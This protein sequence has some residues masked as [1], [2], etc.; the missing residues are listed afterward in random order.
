MAVKFNSVI[1]MIVILVSTAGGAKGTYYDVADN[2]TIGSCKPGKE[3][4]T[5]CYLTLV[6]SLLGNGDNMFNLMNV[7]TP[8]NSNP[9]EHVIVNY[10]FQ[11][12]RGSYTW[13]WATSF[14]YFLY[15]PAHFQF[16]S[17]FFGK[18]EHLHERTVEVT[19]PA[20]CY[21]VKKEFMLLLTQRVR[22]TVHFS[23]I[24]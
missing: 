24:C 21:G 18:P 12:H 5:E 17:L 20:D 11:N 7:F 1:I 2:F 8:P 14:G 16:M 9:P 19:L 4:C 3:N 23:F 10:R 13:F 22:P 6:K 15:Q